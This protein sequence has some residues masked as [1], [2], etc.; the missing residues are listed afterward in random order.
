MEG[1]A[2]ALHVKKGAFQRLVLRKVAV[3]DGGVD[4]RDALGNDSPAAEVR[5][6][7]LAIA[8]YPLGKAYRFAG[9]FKHCV[10]IPFEQRSPMRKLRSRDRV[11]VRLIA[12]PPAVEH[13]KDHRPEF[14]GTVCHPEPVE[15]CTELEMSAA[16]PAGSSDAPPTS[17]PLTFGCSM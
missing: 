10:R 3:G 12:A 8:D 17:P 7:N 11:A 1:S 13:G 6:P 15:G 2:A 5:V 16:K 9:S 4:D 14:H